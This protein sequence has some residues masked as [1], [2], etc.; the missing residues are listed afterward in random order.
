MIVWGA[1]IGF[2]YYAF[3]DPQGAALLTKKALAFL[4]QLGE[5]LT[6]FGRTIAS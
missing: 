5:V 3:Q 2:G 6:T 1:L 4:P